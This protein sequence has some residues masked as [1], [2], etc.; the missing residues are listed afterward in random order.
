MHERNDFMVRRR[1][2]G[3]IDTGFYRDRAKRLHSASFAEIAKRLI[4]VFRSDIAALR[5]WQAPSAFR[6]ASR[7]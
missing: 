2:D 4:E 1:A 6:L 5:T 7:R 3:S